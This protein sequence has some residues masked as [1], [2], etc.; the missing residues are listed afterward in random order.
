MGL[1]RNPGAD[2]EFFPGGGGVSRNFDLQ[3]RSISKHDHYVT[4]CVYTVAFLCKH[5]VRTLWK[6]GGESGGL[7]PIKKKNRDPGALYREQEYHCN[8]A[9]FSLTRKVHKLI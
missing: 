9:P 6:L 8:L 2:P 4:G 1:L 7:S 3:I 5:C